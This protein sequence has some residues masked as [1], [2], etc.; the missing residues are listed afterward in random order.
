MN[1]LRQKICALA[2]VCL[3]FGLSGCWFALGGAAG[4][5]TALYLKGRL[6]EN[7][8]REMHAVHDAAVRAIKDMD[9]PLNKE[10]KKVNS[11]SIESEYPDGTHVWIHTRFLATNST[12]VTIRVGFMGDESRSRDIWDELRRQLN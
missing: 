11:T 1:A 8:S 10:E 2:V 5:G 3:C 6:Q 4:G 7:V 9:L 12:R